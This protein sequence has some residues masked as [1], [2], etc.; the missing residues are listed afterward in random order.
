MLAPLSNNSNLKVLNKGNIKLKNFFLK[1]SVCLW[2][3]A[4]SPFTVRSTK[5]IYEEIHEQLSFQNL[6]IST[7]SIPL[8]LLSLNS[9]GV[10]VRFGHHSSQQCPP[11]FEVRTS[12]FLCSSFYISQ[13]F[14]GLRRSG[15]ASMLFSRLFAN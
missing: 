8:S 6:A 2:P 7:E 11:L 13:P 14:V 9:V 12:F 5:L 3:T 15:K 10:L 4:L 1:S